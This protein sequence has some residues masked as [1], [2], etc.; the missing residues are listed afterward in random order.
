MKCLKCNAPIAEG[1]FFCEECK[2]KPENYKVCSKCLNKIPKDVLF[3][4]H[5]GSTSFSKE[6]DAS[7]EVSAVEEIVVNTAPE[8]ELPEDSAPPK[9]DVPKPEPE[10]DPAEEL[11]K[12]MAIPVIKPGI[13]YGGTAPYKDNA[14][15]Y[16]YDGEAPSPRAVP[17]G[18]YPQKAP[19]RP[20]SGGTKPM[21]EDNHYR[22]SNDTVKKIIVFIAVFLSVVLVGF[23]SIF[24]YMNY[25]K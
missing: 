4:P 14:P 8:M 20:Y 25:F 17:R 22:D 24:L 3:C 19:A 10:A 2:T 13:R 23:S 18:G 9:E 7:I 15:A 5:C 16:R 11:E 12:T 21:A 1:A 6:E